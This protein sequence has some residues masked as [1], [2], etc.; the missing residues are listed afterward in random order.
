[1]IVFSR[2]KLLLFLAACFFMLGVVS[3]A[4]AQSVDMSIGSGYVD[5]G[6]SGWGGPTVTLPTQD[7]GTTLNG[8]VEAGTAGG[9]TTVNCQDSGTTGGSV[10]AWTDQ[11]VAYQSG[12]LT[13]TIP[14]GSNSNYLNFTWTPSIGLHQVVC[15]AQYSGFTSRNVTTSYLDIPVAAIPDTG[16]LDLKYVVLAVTYAPPGSKS[17]V[18]Y[19]NV[20]ALGT[21]TSFS[22]Q[23]T[24]KVATSVSAGAGVGIAGTGGS[25]TDTEST[26]F[27]QEAT[28]SGSVAV[29]KTNTNAL[30]V[31]GPAGSAVGLDHDY[32]IVWVWLNPTINLTV[33]PI[34]SVFTWTGYSYN[35]SDTN[36]GQDLD[37][38]P[39]YVK[40]LKDITSQDPSCTD[41]FTRTARTWDTSGLGALTATDFQQILARD[42]FATDPTYDPTAPDPTGAM[43]FDL[44]QGVALNYFP[45]PPGGQPFTNSQSV[46]YQTT[47]TAGQSASDSYEVGFT[48]DVK[49]SANFIAT[50]NAD[51]NYSNT[52]T[53]TN[54]W[55]RTTTTQGTQTASVSITGPASTD[56]YTGP[57]AFEVFLDNVYGTLM[58][59][60]PE[61]TVPPP[62]DGTSLTV[63]PTTVVTGG[64]VT[65]NSNKNMTIRT[66]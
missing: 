4:N 20:T 65:R 18:N 7:S 24:N 46:T 54:E 22:D 19:S 64:S 56:N 52:T 39:I 15:S 62:T 28:S 3:R 8:Y 34:N 30:V 50:A 42:P 36:S 49:A 66:I 32:D 14:T 27:T 51:F 44:Q 26:S 37:V 63:S 6:I 12:N 1:M 10:F 40:C 17:S 35:S 9:P 61:T 48:I 11:N 47:T 2:K 58:F 25:V 21:A 31:P 13:W 41:A 60:S 23:N 29:N 53:W 57:T 16:S 43:R 59:Y 33:S 5:S 38:V 55:G 45:P